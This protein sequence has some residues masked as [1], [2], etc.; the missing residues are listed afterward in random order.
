MHKCQ[1][2]IR[3]SAVCRFPSSMRRSFVPPTPADMPVQVWTVN[4]DA[5]ME[6]LLD[7]GV[8]GIM[9][10]RVTALKEVFERRGVW[11]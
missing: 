10:D 2:I 5:E 8:D 1:R 7:L 9:S 4:D 11:P 6:R 3:F